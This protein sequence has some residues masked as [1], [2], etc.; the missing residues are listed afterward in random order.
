MGPSFQMRRAGSPAAFTLVELLVAAAIALAVMG[1]IATLLG[2]FS[3]AGTNSQA[4]VDMSN[5]MRAAAKRLRQ[6]L[7]GLTAPLTPPLNPESNAGYFELIEGPWTD[8]TDGSGALITGTSSTSILADTDD[9]LLFTTRSS[10]GPFEGNYNG[11]QIESPTAEVAWFCL[12]STTGSIPGVQL[13]TLYRRQLLVV[14]YVG[15]NSFTTSGTITNNQISTA[16]YG[17]LPTVYNT[18]DISLRYDT[19]LGAGATNILVPNTLADLSR[20]EN[21]FF[22]DVVSGTNWSI[23]FPNTTSGLVFSSSSGREGEDIVLTNVIAFDV[24][25]FDPDIPARRNGTTILYPTDQTYST[26]SSAGF[27]G[28]FLDLG[29]LNAAAPTVLSG[30]GNSRSQLHKVGV[31]GTA[32][33]DTWSTSYENNGVDD[34]NDGIFDEGTNGV[35][36]SSPADGIPDDPG[37]DET[38]P[39]Y[40]R[41]LQA[42]EIRIRCYDPTSREIRQVTV[43]QFFTN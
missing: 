33:Y 24:R 15:N 26:G 5:R 1:A 9:A 6:D 38:A 35:D 2:T 25:V 8:A 30:T 27:S 34:D 7:A 28:C 39:P 40:S 31:T 19:S 29:C 10:T 12:P 36:D 22:H 42:I 14:G 18:F 11:N 4:V 32:T 16:T 37:E 41:P 20:R 3:R 23:R 21:R 13:Q 43:R 17:T